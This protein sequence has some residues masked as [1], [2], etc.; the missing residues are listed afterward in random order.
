MTFPPSTP[1]TDPSLGRAPPATP[2][3]FAGATLRFVEMIPQ[4]IG[5][6]ERLVEDI[7]LNHGSSGDLADIADVAHQLAGTAATLGMPRIGTLSENVEQLIK[8]SLDSSQSPQSV[9][10]RVRPE[11]EALLDAL[12]DAFLD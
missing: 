1:F 11:I 2:P 3:M 7:S 4:R 10:V 9:L 12:E 8:E 6:I 5:T